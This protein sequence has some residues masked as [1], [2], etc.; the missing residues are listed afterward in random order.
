MG[1]SAKSHKIMSS[2]HRWVNSTLV[3]KDGPVAGDCLENKQI[4]VLFFGSDGP[5][6]AGAVQQIT[7]LYTTLKQSP[8]ADE[9]EIVYV[10]SE[11][12]G[13]QASFDQAFNGQAWLAIPFSEA[14]LRAKLTAAHEPNLNEG[15]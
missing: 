14:A 1:K 2:F 11:A 8:Q 4:V 13:N 9:F 15:F 3:N 7:Q 12:G 5:Q 6:L 10:H